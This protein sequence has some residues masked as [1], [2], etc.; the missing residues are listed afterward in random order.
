MKD[1]DWRQSK[2][3]SIGLDQPAVLEIL[4][5]PRPE[6]VGPLPPRAEDHLVPVSDGAQLGARFHLAAPD[7]PHILFFHGNGE[8]V[9]DYD[10]VG[11]RF[12]ATGLSFLAVDFRGYG[13]ST[14]TPRAS[15]LLSDAHLVFAMVREWMAAGNRSGP[16]LLMGRSLG[17]ACAVELAV[18]HMDDIAGLII[19]SGFATT[20]PLLI[21]LGV[22]VN[23][24]GLTEA[25]GF[26][27]VRKIERMTKAILLIHGQNDQIIP[28]A[29]A[30]ILHAQCSA[31][32]KELQIVP[33]A[34][35]NSIIART[36]RMYFEVIKRFVHKAC[37]IRA[38]RRRRQKKS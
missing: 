5:H 15:T 25:D 3:N 2:D 23:G 31:R 18:A 28:V 1:H 38:K 22:D 29:E 6:V 14:G 30:A 7:E 20:L 27:N 26:G 16:L 21:R 32:N 19:E 11:A 37:G 9:N 33:G 8:T 34:D 35:H 36:G 12:S 17:T 4:F 13:I 10:Q 24:L